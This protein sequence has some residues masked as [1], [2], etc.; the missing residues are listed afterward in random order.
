M[1]TTLTA[2][3]PARRLSS[4]HEEGR[5]VSAL[6][7]G[8]AAHHLHEEVHAMTKLKTVTVILPML[9]TLG[10]AGVASAQILTGFY[11]RR[12]PVHG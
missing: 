9:M 2:A 12:H 5:D 8:N 4:P 3:R 6:R 10:F 1:N 7:G 11:D